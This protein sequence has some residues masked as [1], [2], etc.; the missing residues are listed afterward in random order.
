MN[1]KELTKTYI[2]IFQVDKTFALN[3]VC[4]HIFQFCT[5]G[6]KFIWPSTHNRSIQMKHALKK[7]HLVCWFILK[8]FSA[9]KVNP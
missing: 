9:L 7:T 8:Y 2:M 6:L 3:I 4:T 1:Q 5:L